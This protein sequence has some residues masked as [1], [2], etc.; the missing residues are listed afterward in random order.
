MTYAQ[1]ED[2]IPANHGHERLRNNWRCLVSVIRDQMGDDAIETV[3]GQ[4]YRLAAAG[5]AKVGRLLRPAEA[6]AA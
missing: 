3:W 4:G 5:T 1:L 2:Q 6:R